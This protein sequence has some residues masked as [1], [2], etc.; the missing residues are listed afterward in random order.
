LRAHAEDIQRQRE[1]A[2]EQ[3][4]RTVRAEDEARLRRLE[5]ARRS[6]QDA[7]QR[8]ED[9]RQEEEE[10]RRRPVAAS[11]RQVVEGSDTGEPVFDPHFVLGVAPH[12]TEQQ[13]RAAFEEARSK[14]DPEQVSHLGVDV[15]EHYAE[16]SRAVERA[17]RMLAADVDAPT[18]EAGGEPAA[19]NQLVS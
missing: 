19:V 18:P 12:S 5:E 2:E 1:Q 14:Y 16:K 8:E 6:E 4:R 10:L 17:Y 9:A 11:D 15:Q 13:L 3:H 7:R